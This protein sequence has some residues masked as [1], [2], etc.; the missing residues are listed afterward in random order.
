MSFGSFCK[1]ERIR[2][3][4]YL[5]VC[6]LMSF[7]SFCKSERIRSVRHLV[8][9]CFLFLCYSEKVREEEV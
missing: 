6:C 9:S 8:L 2:S 3:V 4:T 1:S 5:V 7:G